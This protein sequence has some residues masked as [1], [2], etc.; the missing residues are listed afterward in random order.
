MYGKTI[1]SGQICISPNYVLCTSA[2]KDKLIAE[3]KTVFM[4]W[5]DSDPKKSPC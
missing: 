2:T 1:N 3:L 4:E 5:Y